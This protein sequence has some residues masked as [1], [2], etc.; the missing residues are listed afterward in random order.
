MDEEDLFTN[1]A[2]GKYRNIVVL[3]GAGISTAAGIPDFRSPGGLFD[4]LRRTFGNRFPFVYDSPESILSRTFA[5]AHPTVYQ[6]DVKPLLKHLLDE[7]IDVSPT[8]THRFCAWLNQQG[9]LRRIYTQNVDGLHLHPTL[10][11]DDNLVVECHG[12]MKEGNIV[13]YGDELP[14]RFYSCCD[15]D[16][17]QTIADTAAVDLMLVFG[18]SL[19][20]LPFSAVPNLAPRGCVRVL[21]NRSLD[22]CINYQISD[23][24]RSVPRSP[25]SLRIGSRKFVTAK[26][27]W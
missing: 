25:S 2:S 11:I 7:T 23:S 14:K 24:D 22:E 26:N 13:L 5:L 12:S 15:E 18:T 21:I 27:L 10:K 6:N 8:E 16:F 20:V 9:W 17:S 19:R 3:T 4:I 1:L